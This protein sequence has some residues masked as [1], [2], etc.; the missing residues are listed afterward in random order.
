[1]IG[2]S[3][4]KYMAEAQILRT[5]TSLHPGGLLSKVNTAFESSFAL[6]MTD[7]LHRRPQG[8]SWFLE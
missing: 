4:D 6:N 1:M 7:R 8:I 3:Q 5:G 2:E